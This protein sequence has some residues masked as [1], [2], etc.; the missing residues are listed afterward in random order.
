MSKI[1]FTFYFVFLLSGYF[2]CNGVGILN[3]VKESCLEVIIS[4][5][6]VNVEYQVTL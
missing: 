3:A 2:F 6:V 4:K 1:F 5:V